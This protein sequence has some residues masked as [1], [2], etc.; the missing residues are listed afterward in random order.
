MY[1]IDRAINI[2][3]AI[4]LT[5]IFREGIYTLVSA[6]TMIYSSRYL[7]GIFTKLGSIIIH[8]GGDING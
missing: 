7:S 3:R 5:L 4:G 8:E 6:D 1:D 2:A